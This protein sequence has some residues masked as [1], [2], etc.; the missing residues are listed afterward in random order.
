M[1]HVIKSRAPNPAPSSPTS[2]V[3][4]AA[5]RKLTLATGWLDLLETRNIPATDGGSI[6]SEEVG[7]TKTRGLILLIDSLTRKIAA[8]DVSAGG[9]AVKI[10]DGR[11][12]ET[13][14]LL[15]R[16]NTCLFLLGKRSP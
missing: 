14:T 5:I 8:L 7:V 4:T 16:R 11:S 3:F 15:V 12:A 6:D 1:S 9:G 10:A 2:S 13:T